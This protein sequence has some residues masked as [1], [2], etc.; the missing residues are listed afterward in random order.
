MVQISFQLCVQR[1][2]A[3]SLKLFSVGA[4]TPWKLANTRNQGLTYCF[5]WSSR[6]KKVMEKMLMQTKFKCLSY[7]WL[8][9]ANS[10][11]NMGEK[12]KAYSSSIWKLSSDRAKNS[13]MSLLNTWSSNIRL[14]CFLLVFNVKENNKHWHQK[15]TCRSIPWATSWLNQVVIKH[16]FIAW[17]CQIMVELQP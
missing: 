9:I 3:H 10:K 17:F 4:F 8:Y 15:Y 16:L 14:C 7:L 6:L 11:Q 1:H 12:G 2:C 13:L 5:V